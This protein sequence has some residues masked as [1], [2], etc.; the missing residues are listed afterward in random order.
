MLF[1]SHEQENFRTCN[2]SGVPTFKDY[3][4]K[5]VKAIFCS[6]KQKKNK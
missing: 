5:F 4:L 1:E 3:L 2:I 6:N